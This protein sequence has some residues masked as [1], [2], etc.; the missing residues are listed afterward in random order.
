MTLSL[1]DARGERALIAVLESREPARAAERSQAAFALL[2]MAGR[3]EGQR[4]PIVAEL[5]RYVAGNPR[6]AFTVEDLQR[7][8]LAFTLLTFE[9]AVLGVEDG[10]T[11][12]YRMLRANACSASAMAEQHG[13]LDALA[14]MICAH[15]ERAPA[16]VGVPQIAARLRKLV[17]ALAD[18]AHP[19]L[20]VRSA[21]LG[22]ALERAGS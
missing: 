6:T 10:L 12:Y 7:F 14:A 19:T 18:S 21:E 8:K 15:L 16:L 3:R 17:E 20:I 13:Y 9:P 1:M 5:L 11:L 22:R 2:L 4:D